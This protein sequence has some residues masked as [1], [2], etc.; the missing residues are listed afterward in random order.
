MNALGLLGVFI[1]GGLGSLSR[2]LV[3]R[4]VIAYG[5]KGYF[6]LATLLA[7][8]A[9]CLVMG[10]IMYFTLR[11]KIVSEHWT[12]FWLVGFCGGFSTFS[13]FS[14]ENWLLLKD[15]L[16]GMLALNVAISVIMCVAVFV[17]ISRMAIEPNL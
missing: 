1:G 13:T 17:M 7:N 14:Y 11:G 2:Y 5:Y 15:G 8:I 6:P 4:G 12:L 3:S 10:M 9:A 16:Y